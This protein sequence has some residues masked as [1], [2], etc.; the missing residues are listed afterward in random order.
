M[1]GPSFLTYISTKFGTIS[2]RQSTSDD[3]FKWITIQKFEH[4]KWYNLAELF[5]EFKETYYGTDGDFHRRT[6]TNWLKIYALTNELEMGMKRSDGKTW[7]RFQCTS[8]Q[9]T[10]I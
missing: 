10:I 7:I 6:L 9:E 1:S 3:F 8:A 4:F 2:L 5:S